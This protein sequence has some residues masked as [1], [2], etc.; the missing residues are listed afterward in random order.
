[1]HHTGDAHRE[2]TATMTAGGEVTRG[3]TQRDRL[4]RIEQQID[5]Q[6]EQHDSARAEDLKH[7]AQLIKQEI[8]DYR[9]TERA[10]TRRQTVWAAIGLVMT[11]TGIVLRILAG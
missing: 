5:A 9:A 6:A 10:N 11:I 3:G 7:N 4:A 8:N 1:M 2:V